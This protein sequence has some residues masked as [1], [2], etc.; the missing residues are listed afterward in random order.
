MFLFAL[1]AVSI[2]GNLWWIIVFHF[3]TIANSRWPLPLQ[4]QWS[5]WQI[6]DCHSIDRGVQSWIK[7]FRD[8]PT[9]TI[10]MAITVTTEWVPDHQEF[11]SLKLRWCGKFRCDMCEIIQFGRYKY[12]CKYIYTRVYTNTNTGWQ[13]NV[14]QWNSKQDWQRLAEQCVQRVGH[15][16]H[17][18][19]HSHWWLI[20]FIFLKS[21][22]NSGMW[23][24]WSLCIGACRTC[25]G[26]GA[27]KKTGL[28]I[29]QKQ[30]WFNSKTTCVVGKW[31][32]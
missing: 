18:H 7:L 24:T 25:A 30:R 3:S 11:T 22:M 10:V 2:K 9:L 5:N 12:K 27:R 29:K 15:H 28:W 32:V 20:F 13:L 17:H 21:Y 23:A 19:Y 14:G 31:K 6:L 8:W 16:H 1:S 4:W 26:I